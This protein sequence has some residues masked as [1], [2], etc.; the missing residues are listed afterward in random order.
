MSVLYKKILVPLDG[1][2]HSKK[3]CRHA[4]ALAVACGSEIILVHCYDGP[5]NL[6]GGEAREDV[7]AAAQAE[8]RAMLASCGEECKGFGVSHKVVV[9]SGDAARVIIRVANEEKCEQIVM[10]TRGLS[11]LTSLVLGSVSHDVLEYTDVP[12]LLVK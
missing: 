4:T 3:A 6:I 12:V 9:Q 1:S 2:E 7:V 5:A 8:S 10:G 11:E